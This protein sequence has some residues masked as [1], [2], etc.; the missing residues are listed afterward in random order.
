MNSLQQRE[1]IE[2]HQAKRIVSVR[3]DL[4]N[5]FFT[6]LL[7]TAVAY[8][9]PFSK[10]S[11]NPDAS[12]QAEATPTTTIP[13]RA[14][15]PVRQRPMKEEDD[16]QSVLHENLQTTAQNVSRS[17]L[18]SWQAAIILLSHVQNVLM[19]GNEVPPSPP[20]FQ[21]E[22]DPFTIE[23][24]H[25]A[26]DFQGRLKED[27]NS[28][29]KYQQYMSRVKVTNDKLSTLVTQ[30]NDTDVLSSP[31]SVYVVKFFDLAYTMSVLEAQLRELLTVLDISVSSKETT[32]TDLPDDCYETCYGQQVSV[33][34]NYIT[35]VFYYVPGDIA[36]LLDTNKE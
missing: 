21:E 13:H 4:I 23:H 27:Y 9:V 28:L 5:K 22:R 31:E 24:P 2:Q 3:M 25:P 36:G 1:S 14:P 35:L 29:L 34:R 32:P 6:I 7:L 11:E 10:S 19:M 33:L 20:C 15:P 17:S 12:F 26:T 18:E 30:T 16:G 8:T